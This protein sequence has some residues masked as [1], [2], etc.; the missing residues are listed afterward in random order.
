MPKLAPIKV[1]PWTRQRA[2][3]ADRSARHCLYLGDCLEVLSEFPEGSVDLA[4]AD[5]PFNI[6]YEYDSYEDNKTDAEYVLWCRKWL[7][8][9]KRVLKSNGTFWLAI[10]DRYVSDLDI[11]ARYLGFIRRSW[12]IWHYTFGVNSIRKLTPSHTHLLYYVL[13]E[14]NFTFNAEAVAVPSM[15][16][17]KYADSRAKPNGR[18]PNDVWLLDSKNAAEEGI[19]FKEGTDTWYASRICGTFKERTDHPC[20]M[21]LVIMER[22]VNLSSNQGDLVLDPFCGSGTTLKAAQNLSR[23]SVGVEIGENYL[24]DIVV[25]RLSQ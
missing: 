7:Y 9:V 15:R 1:V 24:R 19:A 11:D 17:L 5:P 6:G 16:Q 22:I 14:K 10:G 4:F 21:P 13:D 18:L 20:Q 8:Q 12:V 2:Y 23:R 25:P 3:W